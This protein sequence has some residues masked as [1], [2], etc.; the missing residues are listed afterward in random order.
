M[1][2][3]RSPDGAGSWSSG[4][5]MLNRSA[6]VGNKASDQGGGIEQDYGSVM[7]NGSTV[8]GNRATNLAGGIDENFGTVGLDE[9]TAW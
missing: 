8:I 2:G 5:L 7:L 4:T 1:S 6:I 9:L 3:N